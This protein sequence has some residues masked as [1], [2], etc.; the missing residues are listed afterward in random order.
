MLII[1]THKQAQQENINMPNEFATVF[2]EQLVQ[3]DINHLNH[4][5]RESYFMTLLTR[6][7]DMILHIHPDQRT[8]A[9]CECVLAT[10]PR[11]I[12]H[13]PQS[14]KN[15]M[16]AIQQDPY[17]IR[18][19]DIPTIEQILTAVKLNGYV[20][21]I[22]KNQTIDICIVALR[23]QRA[24]VKYVKWDQIPEHQHSILFLMAA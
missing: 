23:N 21:D 10:K 20:L 22:I 15:C 17:S 6:D 5:Q 16:I 1:T 2:N 18:Y 19:I 12:K 3:R 8:D 7:P 11:L 14:H 4:K 13:L 24:A 9:M